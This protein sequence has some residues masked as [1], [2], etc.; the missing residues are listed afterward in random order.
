MYRFAN[1]IWILLPLLFSCNQPVNSNQQDKV[2]TYQEQP[3]V[4]KEI[5]ALDYVAHHEI[6]NPEAPI[7]PQCYTKT[8][9]VN[10]PCYVCHQTYQDDKRTNMM[11]DGFQQGSYAFSDAGVN[12]SWK[13]LFV[14]RRQFIAKTPD[15]FIKSYIAQDNY[16]ELIQWMKSDQ[17][18]GEVLSIENLSSGKNAFDQHGLAKDGSRWVAY[19]YKPLP[20]TFWPTNGSTDDSMIRLSRNF[21]EING[22]FS[23]DVYYANLALVELTISDKEQ[24]SVI[25]LNEKIIGE[26][27]NNDGKLTENVTNI[28]HRK[29]YLGDAKNIAVH[30]MLYP[31][32]TAFLHTVR[33]VDVN[34]KGEIGPS[35]RMKEVRYMKKEKLNT[36]TA[37]R[38]KYYQEFKE[39][40]FE[41][42]PKAIDKKDRGISNNFGWLLTGFIED[43]NGKLRKQ[44]HE[45]QFSCVGCHKSIGST[46]DQTFSF[47][48]KVA[49]AKGWQYIDLKAIKDTPTLGESQGEFLTYLERVGGGDEFRQNDEMIERWFNS[50]GSVNKAKVSKLNNIYELITPS[51]E[52][53]YQ[54]NKAYLAVVK[55]QSY[56]FGRDAVIK[57]ATNVLKN[58]DTDI[59]PLKPE[60]RYDWDIR[61]DWDSSKE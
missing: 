51:P 42:L 15:T 47:P 26:D 60:A 10:N 31:E 49:G 46:I 22:E 32:G 36:Q 5:T 55:E 4:N 40:H 58:I 28:T 56:L 59:P 8:N 24:T 16:Q 29:N 1:L 33:Y 50:D 57:P 7:P 52:R 43:E 19:N 20:S 30:Y 54:L 12:N 44:H 21:S 34:D 13:N 14:D 6:Y 37:L 39:K 17:W 41:N 25:P 9:S 38:S 48:R 35:K 23:K 27:I 3:N 53:A 11:R 18:S 61:L 45:E 2:N